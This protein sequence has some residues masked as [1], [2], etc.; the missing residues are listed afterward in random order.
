MEPNTADP[1][2]EVGLAV[3]GL[4]RQLRRALEQEQ[5]LHLH[6]YTHKGTGEVCEKRLDKVDTRAAKELAGVLREL[7]ELMA[8]TGGGGENIRVEM[9][10]E[11]E[12][13]AR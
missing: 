7:T 2:R 9:D 5:Q 13:L 1:R 4:A 3:A 6:T 11:A 12:Q 8:E 10:A